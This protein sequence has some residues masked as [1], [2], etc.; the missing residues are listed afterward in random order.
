MEIKPNRDSLLI[1]KV[2][3]QWDVALYCTTSGDDMLEF[4]VLV[5]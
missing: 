2:F 3:E 5:K 4:M 1:K